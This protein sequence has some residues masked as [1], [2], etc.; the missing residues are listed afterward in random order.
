MA[1]LTMDFSGLTE[2]LEVEDGGAT[3][4]LG[5]QQKWV[6]PVA[7]V[8]STINTAGLSMEVKTEPGDVDIETAV[9]VRISS[10]QAWTEASDVSALN[11]QTFSNQTT[12]AFTPITYTAGTR[13]V[14]KVTIQLQGAIDAGETTFS[15]RVKPIFHNSVN[16]KS[17]TGGVIFGSDPA[18]KDG[19]V[20]FHS[21]EAATAD[22]PFITVDY[23]PA[24]PAAGGAILTPNSKYWGA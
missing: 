22:T 14:L 18:G 1:T 12:G 15:L 13:N 6:L 16:G 23:T 9:A 3:T 10:G 7:L 20:V 21:D 11:A 19:Y 5:F 8:G 4:H 17:N 24:A 2:D